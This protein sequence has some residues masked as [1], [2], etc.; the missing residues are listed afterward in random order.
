MLYIII[1]YCAIIILLYGHMIVW[2]KYSAITL[3]YYHIIILL[4]N[5]I[6]I[7]YN[8]WNACFCFLFP[9]FFLPRVSTCHHLLARQQ[10][11]V[12]SL[13]TWPDGRAYVVFSP[14]KWWFFTRINDYQQT[15]MV[16]HDLNSKHGGLTRNASWPGTTSGFDEIYISNPKMGI[17]KYVDDLS[18]HVAFMWAPKSGLDKIQPTVGALKWGVFIVGESGLLYHQLV[19]ST[20]EHPPV[21]VVYV[22]TVYIP[23]GNLT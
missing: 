13:S 15:K 7:I 14:Q 8:I 21:G 4:Y 10:N 5:T 6:Y 1:L 11:M 22:Y 3:L 9:W 20:W 23:S 12:D 16:S 19:R 17:D 2:L 18:T